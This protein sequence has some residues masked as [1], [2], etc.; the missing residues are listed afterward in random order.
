MT[1]KKVRLN[2]IKSFFGTV[3]KYCVYIA[4]VYARW[5]SLAWGTTRN[6]IQLRW[7]LSGI[8]AVHEAGHTVFCWSRPEF[9]FIERVY[10]R[11]DGEGTTRY[12]ID[13][14]NRVTQKL[15]MIQLAMTGMAAERLLC[16][17][18]IADGNTSD[19]IMI[20]KY[21]LSAS[22]DDPTYPL[23]LPPT[24]ERWRQ[25][26]QEVIRILP[27]RADLLPHQLQLIS[28]AY[29]MS[30]AF[31]EAHRDQ[32]LDLARDLVKKKEMNGKQI[33]DQ[34]GPRPFEQ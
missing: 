33:R 18:W 12:C 8:T 24:A 25:E 11:W 5:L 32:I 1:A 31:V 2:K 22:K 26:S 28:D 4:Q 7:R 3:A 34:L 6:T 13:R 20:V 23:P 15:M 17:H 21:A 14:K 29:C 19:R 16:S 30:R 10:A 9:I 27:A